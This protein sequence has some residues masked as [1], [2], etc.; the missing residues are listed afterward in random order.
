M[1]ASLVVTI[2][3]VVVDREAALRAA[4]G[5]RADAVLPDEIALA[6]VQRLHDVAGIHDVH[7]AVVHDGRRLIG[8]FIHG[9]HPLELEIL[10]VL[11]RDLIQ[12]AVIGGVIIVADHQ[13]VAGIGI[14][15]HGVGHRREILHFTGDYQTSRRRRNRRFGAATQR[16]ACGSAVRGRCLP[17][18]HRT[19]RDFAGC[20]QRLISGTCAP[21]KSRMNAVTLTYACSPRL[22]GFPRR[23]GAFEKRN[24]F[25]GV[26]SPQLLRKSPPANAEALL[27]PLRSAPWQPE[28]LA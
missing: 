2:H 1:C 25:A 6:R 3:F 15:Q 24:Q 20:R 14:A 11:R 19:D 9:P 27:R 26:R 18:G 4:G 22:P 7:D 23:H 12:R 8:S 5:R 21:L 28:Q 13:P 16:F 17:G 10:H